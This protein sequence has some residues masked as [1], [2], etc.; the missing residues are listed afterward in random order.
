MRNIKEELLKEKMNPAR[1]KRAIQLIQ[2]A[3]DGDFINKVD[4]SNTMRVEPVIDSTG[5]H[6]LCHELLYFA[7]G[8]VVQGLKD[9]RYFYDANDAQELDEVS[10]KHM[11]DNLKDM[12]SFIWSTEAYNFFNRIK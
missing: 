2:R 12:V 11:A 6:E 8:F 1:S 10:T 9:G 3:L 7:G 4:F 5:L